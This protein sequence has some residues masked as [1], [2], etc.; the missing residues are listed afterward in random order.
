MD[1]AL[2]EDEYD[3]LGHQARTGRSAS[4]ASSL[5]PL[6]SL[7]RQTGKPPV[8]HGVPTLAAKSVLERDVHSVT[9]AAPELVAAWQRSLLRSD[10]ALVDVGVAPPPPGDWRVGGQTLV[11]PRR[12]GHRA[13]AAHE[14]TAGVTA[15]PSAGGDDAQAE[16]Q[17]QRIS[18]RIRFFGDPRLSCG[19]ME[20]AQQ[21]AKPAARANSRGETNDAGTAARG[22]A[23][24]LVQEAYRVRLRRS[25]SQ[26]G[27]SRSGSA[28]SSVKIATTIE[29][30]AALSRVAA[31][32]SGGA[33][34][35]K[36][37]ATRAEQHNGP[38]KLPGGQTESARARIGIEPGGRRSPLEAHRDPRGTVAKWWD[39]RFAGAASRQRVNLDVLVHANLEWTSAWVD[40]EAR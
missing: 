7:V 33:S 26:A 29:R 3:P 4:N 21:K 35:A 13:A 38:Q 39:D 25:T 15:N 14:R 11:S 12:R 36:A 5:L 8:R 22:G 23:S 16:L 1:H 37:K 20:R 31:A 30:G 34:F 17:R 10:A 28:G 19:G 40:T 6:T 32:T 24:G 27:S 18:N 2:H 9:G